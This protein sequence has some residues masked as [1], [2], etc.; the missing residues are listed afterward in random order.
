MDSIPTGNPVPS[1]D[2]QA[3]L[4]EAFTRLR[5][6]LSQTIVGQAALVERLRAWLAGHCD[7]IALPRRWRMRRGLPT[8]AMPHCRCSW[9]TIP[10]VRSERWL[11][12]GGRASRCR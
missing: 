6:D 5:D 2:A 3:R 9:W 10:G 11:R 1:G 12:R 8:M 7:P 4:H